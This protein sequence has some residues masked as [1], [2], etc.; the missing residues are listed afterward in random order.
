MILL[1]GHNLFDKDR[2]LQVRWKGDSD[3]PVE[4]A[5]IQHVGDLRVARQQI[6]RGTE[7]YQLWAFSEPCKSEWFQQILGYLVLLVKF[8]LSSGRQGGEPLE[9]ISLVKHEKVLPILDFEETMPDFDFDW[10][11]HQNCLASKPKVMDMEVLEEKQS[12]M[13]I[14]FSEEEKGSSSNQSVG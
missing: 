14:A 4:C 6:R 11:F 9:P 5:A 8:L 10:D 7:A 1:E 2:P 13:I 3:T 12:T